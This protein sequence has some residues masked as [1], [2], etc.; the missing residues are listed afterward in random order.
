MTAI[1]S[2][3]L[4]IWSVVIVAMTMFDRFANHFLTCSVTDFAACSLFLPSRLA[5]TSEVGSTHGSA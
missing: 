4:P 2:A 5:S 1:H 3:R